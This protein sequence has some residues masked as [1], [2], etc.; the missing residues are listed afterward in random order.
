MKY[1]TPYIKFYSQWN[2]QINNVQ[3][4]E[5]ILKDTEEKIHTTYKD[6]PFTIT[7]DFKIYNIKYKRTWT[8]A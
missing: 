3:K 8:D 1:N 2:N 7:S 4:K 6:R 5:R